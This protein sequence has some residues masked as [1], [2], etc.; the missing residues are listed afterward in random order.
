MKSALASMGL[1]ESYCRPPLVEM[2]DERRAELKAR[3][4]MLNRDPA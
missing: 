3:L 2:S 4:A 1:R